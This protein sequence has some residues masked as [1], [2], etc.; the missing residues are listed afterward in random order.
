MTFDSKHRSDSHWPVYKGESF[1]L[2]EPD[3]GKYYAS[4]NAEKAIDYLQT[5]RIRGSNNRRS[6]HSE[7]SNEYIRDKSTLPC[8][9][10]RIAFRDI[11]NSIDYRTVKAC[12]VPPKVFIA[13]QAPYL[14]WPRG[15][16]KDQA[17]LLGV[18]SSIPLDWYARRFV[19]THLSFFIFNSLPIPRPAPDNNACKRVVELAG[20]L[21]C[22][23]DRFAVWAKV[24]GVSCGPL[25]DNEKE[26]MIHELDAVVS[27]L[28][29]LTQ[30]QIIHIFE[31]YHKT[32]DY[33]EHLNGVLRHFQNWKS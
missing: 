9:A 13:N 26:D 5:K 21:A 16:E 24:V 20:R 22:P 17:F 23:N 7:F 28:Y 30:K 10:P 6:P 31:T 18:L 29:G 4:A 11:T 25:D 3:T 33:Q 32:W 12:L 15:N 2:W 8:F 1:D 19:G 27:N 14:L